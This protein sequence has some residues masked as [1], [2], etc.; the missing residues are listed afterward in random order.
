VTPLVSFTDMQSRQHLFS[1]RALKKKGRVS[2]PIIIMFLICPIIC[3]QIYHS[4]FYVYHF[5]CNNAREYFSSFGCKPIHFLL[6][7][8]YLCCYDVSHNSQ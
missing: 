7:N 1:E 3:T 5:F 4:I 8:H 2:I 6:S